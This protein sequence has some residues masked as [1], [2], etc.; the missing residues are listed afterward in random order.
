MSDVIIDQEFFS[1]ARRGFKSLSEDQKELLKKAVENSI[2]ENG[3]FANENGETDLYQSSFGIQLCTIMG[4]D[5]NKDVMTE[6]LRSFKDATGLDFLHVVSLARAWRFYSHDSLDVGLYSRIAEKVEYNRCSDGAWNQ[7]AG[8][9]YGSVYGTVLAIAAYQNL[10]QTI[11]EELKVIKALRGLR[12]ADGAF[13]TDHG[14]QNGT[15]PSTAF[16]AIIL[17]F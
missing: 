3:S 2:L 14:G 7:A 6:Y 1:A 12:S 9:H 13:G 8:T 17:N 10:D 4:I 15:T 16:A 11:P 5:K